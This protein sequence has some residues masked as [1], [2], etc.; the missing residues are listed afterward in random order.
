M[1]FQH[2]KQMKQKKKKINSHFDSSTMPSGVKGPP[3]PENTLPTIVGFRGG[4]KKA[5]DVVDVGNGFIRDAT[6]LQKV[7]ER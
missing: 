6:G 5:F 2:S 3:G 4:E 1:R 7:K